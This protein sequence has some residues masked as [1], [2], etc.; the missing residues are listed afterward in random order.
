MISQ[1]NATLYV[2]SI[3]LC[4]VDSRYQQYPERSIA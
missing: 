1:L 2:N 3:S 4:A